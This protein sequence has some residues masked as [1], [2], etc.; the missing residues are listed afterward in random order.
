MAHEREFE[1]IKNM[2]H[3]NVISGVETFFNKSRSEVSIVMEYIE[4]KEI[5]DV[6]GEIGSYSEKIA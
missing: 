3:P 4:G 1:L 5:F 2:Q 6:I